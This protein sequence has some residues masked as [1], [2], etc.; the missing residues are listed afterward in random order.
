MKTKASEMTRL[1]QVPLVPTWPLLRGPADS[2]WLQNAHLLLPQPWKSTLLSGL[3]SGLCEGPH[4]ALQF[5][6]CSVPPSHIKTSSRYLISAYQVPGA[7]LGSE[8]QQG[9]CPSGTN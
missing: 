5:A 4:I 1:H 9:G 3:G 8:G 2:L 6:G 7:V